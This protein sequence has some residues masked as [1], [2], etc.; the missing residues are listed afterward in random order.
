MTVL[1]E[2][3]GL[4]TQIIGPVIDVEFSNGNLPEIFDALEIYTQDG[5]KPL[6]RFNSFSAKTR[7]ALL[8]CLLQTV[9]KEE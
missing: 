3:E 2:N 5:Q 9:C 7:C 1:A 6:P 8:R 4:I